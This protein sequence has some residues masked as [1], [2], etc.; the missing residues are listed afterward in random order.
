MTY[1]TVSTV[2]SA[3]LLR[4]LVHL[5]VLDDQVAGIETLGIRVCLSI[6]EKTEQELSRLYWPSSTG[7]TKLLA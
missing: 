6:L 2:C 3:T 7:N 4:G 5:D 1:T